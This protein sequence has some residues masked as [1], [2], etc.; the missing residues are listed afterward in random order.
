MLFS[1][2]RRLKVF[3]IW[4]VHKA[5]I[6]KNQPFSSWALPVARLMASENKINQIIRAKLSI[7]ED[8]FLGDNIQH[9]RGWYFWRFLFYC[10]I[11]YSLHLVSLSQPAASAVLSFLTHFS[12]L[13]L[14]SYSFSNSCR[15]PAALLYFRNFCW[16]LQLWDFLN[17]QVIEFMKKWDSLKRFLRYVKVYQITLF[18]RSFAF[19]SFYNSWCL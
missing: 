2:V 5:A 15:C 12:R 13:S 16:Y 11:K 8:Y 17:F 6:R 3:H 14:W 4:D 9:L 18:P 19:F 10:K 7:L 1:S